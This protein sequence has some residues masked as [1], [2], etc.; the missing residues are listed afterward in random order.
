MEE[1][2]LKYKILSGSLILVCLDL[3]Y[4]IFI[5]FPDYRYKVLDITGMAR[6]IQSTLIIILFLIIIK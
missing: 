4:N 6:P 1:N 5:L 3:I 2:N